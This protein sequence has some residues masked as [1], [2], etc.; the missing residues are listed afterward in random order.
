MGVPRAG[1]GQEMWAGKAVFTTGEAAEV[2]GV[3]QQTIIRCFDSG[4]LHGFKVPG[5]KFRRIPRDELLNFMRENDIPTSV[6][7]GG[8]RRVLVA[9]SEPI[10]GEALA[11]ELS[12]SGRVAARAAHNIFDAGYLVASFRPE[13][14]VWD[15]RSPGVD[16]RWVFDRLRGANGDPAVRCVLVASA[17][18]ER[19]MVRAADAVVRRP[20]DPGYLLS[21]LLELIPQGAAPGDTR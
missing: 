3:S 18:P 9:L 20:L 2:C 4:R 19:E 7:D 8:P 17:E 15:G 10:E 16:A 1:N 11:A 13:A 14:L 12:S 21:K 6:L 5:S